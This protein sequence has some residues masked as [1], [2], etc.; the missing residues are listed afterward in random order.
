MTKQSHANEI[1]DAN[2]GVSRQD[3]LF[4]I[5]S[6][7]GVSPAY[8]STLYNNARKASKVAS[9]PT[10]T[11][12]HFNGKSPVDEIPTFENIEQFNKPNLRMLR[13][14]L[15]KALKDT[16][17]KFGLSH[18]IGSI[19]FGPGEFTTRLTVN[20]GSA[21]DVVR[22]TFNDHCAS[23]GLK[24]SDFGREF[25][26]NGSVFT[27]TGL[28]PNR[29]KYPISGVGARGGKYKFT[30]DKVVRVLI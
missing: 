6:M 27:I 11:D 30:A 22:D 18:K 10:L 4:M 23:Y 5:T 16:L 19:S 29:R 15:D 14:E 13:V 28:K 7:V 2:V 20:C 24:P 21:D 3:V 1:Y 8:A 17:V 25:R 12:S 9:T 26:T